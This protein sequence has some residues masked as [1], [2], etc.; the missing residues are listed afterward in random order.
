MSPYRR[1]AFV[2]ALCAC[3]SAAAAAQEWR[4]DAALELRV[5][6]RGK[7]PLPGAEIVLELVGV[8]P[9]VGPPLV[10]TDA[11]GTAAVFGLAE[12]RWVLVLHHAGTQPYSAVIE[13]EAGKRAVVVAGPVRDAAAPPVNVD[14][15]KARWTPPPPPPEPIPAPEPTPTPAPPPARAEPEPEPAP[16]PPAEPEPE[17]AP[18]APTE[19]A[20]E[21]EPA[22]PQEA[23]APPVTP[24]PEAP[25]PAVPGPAEP[26]PAV[27][28]TSTP[29][30]EPVPQAAAADS[31][32]PP[33]PPP[34]PA[35]EAPSPGAP[36]T[37]AAPPKTAL[38]EPATPEPAAPEPAAPE[39]AP[40]APAV[41]GVRAA[42]NGTC[43]ECKPGEWAAAA[44]RTAAAGKGCPAGAAD[45]IRAAL[46]T[47]AA[48]AGAFRLYA[49]PLLAVGS[50]RPVG[51][52]AVA[53]EAAAA[54]APYTRPDGACQVV[55]VVL[56][57]GASFKGY[58][59]GSGD[60]ERSGG[61]I[62]AQACDVGGAAFTDHPTVVKGS[63]AV[64]VFGLFENRSQRRRWAELTA[65]FTPDDPRWTP[66]APSR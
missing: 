33:A 34:A 6:D 61:C 18:A 5:T 60:G 19:P 55:A 66:A 32:A 22:P 41:T 17:P 8:E 53:T 27:P 62:G 30:A 38:P 24:E 37:E 16:P 3:L 36:P 9:R 45:E 63:E 10:T 58:A 35:P 47:L 21:P 14:Y 56:P 4:G 11:T 42:Y 46:E 25:E 49:G 64:V 31:A 26:Q 52:G 50:G 44:R 29:P 59:Y 15:R 51:G 48:E 43:P 28:E 57:R 39:P 2:A 40:P 65:Y 23:P 54:L 1:V 20:P 7:K 12:G 13:L